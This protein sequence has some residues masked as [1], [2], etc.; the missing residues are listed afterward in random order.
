MKPFEQ[1]K[2]DYIKQALEKYGSINAT[3]RAIGVHRTTIVR[4]KKKLDEE[5]II[6][7][8][9]VKKKE[10]R[11]SNIVRELPKGRTYGD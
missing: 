4:Y 1:V 5:G 11:P 9:P 7:N 2:L 10:E 6:V 3:A 8:Y